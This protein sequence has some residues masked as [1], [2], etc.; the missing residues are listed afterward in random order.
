MTTLHVDFSCLIINI[1]NMFHA[2]IALI[3]IGLVVVF[4]D[5]SSDF[6]LALLRAKETLNLIYQRYEFGDPVTD[7]FFFG[8]LNLP[9]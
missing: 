1:T 4:G 3:F 5:S 6:D 7:Q 2:F 9:R 8:I